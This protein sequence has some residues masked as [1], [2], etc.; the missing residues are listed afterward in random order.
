M[1]SLRL[2]TVAAIIVAAFV[3]SFVSVT[4]S[5][6][7]YSSTM[8]D[9]YKMLASNLA[10]TV[11]SML[12]PD[13]LLRYYSEAKAIGAYDD[14]KYWNDEA[15]RADFDAQADAI[16]D[17]NY[18]ETLD[19]LFKFKD[20]NNITFLYLQKVEGNMCTYIFDADRADDRCQ[21]GTSHVISQAAQEMDH[22]ENG[23]PAFI[24]NETYG[25]LCT[26]AEPVFDRSGDP[27]ALVGVD[28]SMDDIMQDR[29]NYLRNFIF[30]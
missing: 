5:Y 11:A 23:I 9:H 10:K 26:S 8:D 12:N 19:T 18:Y 13:D 20:G 27:V 2:K 6:H 17:A 16:K 21:L 29:A 1:I 7:V 22:P 4:V 3:L 15:Y 30:L 24:S 25:W 28:I 14:E